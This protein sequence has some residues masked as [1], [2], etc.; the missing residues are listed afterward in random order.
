MV[1]HKKRHPVVDLIAGGTG[2]CFEALS[3]H[4]LGK[5]QTVERI[6]RIFEVFDWLSFRILAFVFF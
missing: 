2:G 3:C 5:L 6:A 1:E 4:P